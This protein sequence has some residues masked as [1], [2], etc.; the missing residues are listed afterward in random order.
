MLDADPL[1]LAL[2]LIALGASAGSLVTAYI[3][4]E[5]NER[6]ALRAWKNGARFAQMEQDMV[7]EANKHD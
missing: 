7:R 4:M 5:V 3:L 6:M 1:V 2:V